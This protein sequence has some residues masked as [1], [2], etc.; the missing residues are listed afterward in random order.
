[1]TRGTAACGGKHG[2]GVGGAA[3]TEARLEISESSWSRRAG[4]REEALSAM[5]GFSAST[6]SFAAS[7]SVDSSRQYTYL[8]AKDRAH[9]SEPPS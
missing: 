6:T 7:G 1:M 2:S 9:T 3:R 4:S 8:P 5:T